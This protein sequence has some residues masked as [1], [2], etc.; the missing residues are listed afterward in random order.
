M[1]R[2]F[3]LQTTFRCGSEREIGDPG[4]SIGRQGFFKSL[5]WRGCMQMSSGPE[6]SQLA[7][8]FCLRRGC[9]QKVMY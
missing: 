4:G 2:E 8:D 5:F 6:P 1:G 7:D 3:E 9:R